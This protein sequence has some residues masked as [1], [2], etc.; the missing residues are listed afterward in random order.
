MTI[1]NTILIIIGVI[2]TLIGILAFFIPS[3]A[4]IINF[5]GGPRIKA[6]GAMIIGIILLI[7]GLIIE[8]P[9]G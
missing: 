1:V 4:R 9:M 6:I 8:L 7:I 3:I 2:V 5:P